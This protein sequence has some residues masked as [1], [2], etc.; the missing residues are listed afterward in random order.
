[1]DALQV[2]NIGQ[3]RKIP[4]N[5]WRVPLCAVRTCAVRPVFARVA[6]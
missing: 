2:D 4:Q 3:P 1:M 6:G 5:I